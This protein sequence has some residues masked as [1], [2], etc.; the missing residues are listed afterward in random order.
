MVTCE[1]MLPDS[2]DW[3]IISVVYA[4]N[5]ETERKLLWS[6]LRDLSVD[7]RIQGRAW[8]VMGDF[9]QTLNPQKHS[10]PA[11]Q[12]INR[13]MLEFRNTLH[14]E[15]LS[16]LTFKGETFTW[17]NKSASRP[18]AKKLDRVLINEYWM[19]Q[20]PASY[21]KFGE[22]DFSDHASCGIVLDHGSLSQKRPFKFFNY[23]LQNSDFLS[24]I[25]D[26]W[27]SCSI[28]GSA[29]FRVSR[30][31]KSLKNSIRRFRK[32]NYSG[33]EK[34]TAE[35]HEIM[36]YR[37]Q[38]VLS[39]P[40]PNNDL[41][42]LE[43]QKRWGILASAEDAFHRQKSR[44]TWLKDGDS[45]SAYFHRVAAG[46]KVLNHIHYLVDEN[47]D[48]VESD[49]GIRS[50]CVNHFQNFLGGDVG[51]KMFVQEDIDLLL[52]YR[53][54]SEQ[55]A[56]LQAEFSSEDIKEAFF[57]LPRNKSCGPDGYSAEFFTESWNIVGP[58][59]IEA[60]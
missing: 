14:N 28:S 37:Q 16:D 54:T 8:L 51:E 38:R 13:R 9:N 21:A 5:D 52:L 30:K 15:D 25:A 46:R 4:S 33:I 29:M 59:V 58:E 10:I 32:Q 49:Q 12:S 18:V 31:L 48:R 41:L 42:E 23:L 6:E 34:R 44:V 7:R 55:K 3:I 43:A 60:V 20:F 19:N 50:H 11:A 17:W 2:S 56:F 26:H 35:A 53:C 45:N 57:Y 27:F 47:G 24:I 40:S 36:L 22:P 39:D 1:V